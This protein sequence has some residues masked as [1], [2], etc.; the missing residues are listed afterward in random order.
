MADRTPLSARRIPIIAEPALAQAVDVWRRWLADERR[1]SDHTLDAYR[2]DLAS[3]FGFLSTHLGHA[4]GLGDL[5]RLSA[6]D[7]RAY[8]AR[9][10]A[11]GLARSSTARAMSTLRNFFAHL[12][13]TGSVQNAAIGA[14]R[15]PR[16]AQSIPK[17]LSEADALETLSLAAN[18]HPTPWIADRDVALLTLLYGCGLRL[19]EALALNRGDAPQ[20]GGATM[21]I[22]GKGNKQR[23]VPVLAVVV[24]A[25]EAYLASV[26]FKLAPGDPLFVGA[27]GKRLNAGVVQRQMRRLGAAL[28]LP[29]TATPH[30]LRHSFATHLLAGGGDL[31]TIQELLG[32]ASLSSTQRYTAI[33]QERLM[34]VYRD[35]HPRARGE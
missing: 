3:F 33:D 9:R 29:K 32:H 19:G 1:C 5:A 21:V 17:P 20:G 13:R 34:R 27:R 24:E 18:L 31:R 22:T 35:A 10:G 2:R 16:Q 12:E 26:P 28:G 25:I 23:V 6:A 14:I 7:F 15:T 11:Q 30:A 4:P 8:L